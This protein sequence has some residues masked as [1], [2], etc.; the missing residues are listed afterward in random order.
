[1]RIVTRNQLARPRSEVEREILERL[2][3]A[4][5]SEKGDTP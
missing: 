3:W 4:V 2:G 1:V 5:L